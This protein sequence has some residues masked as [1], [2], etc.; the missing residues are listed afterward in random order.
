MVLDE[1]KETDDVFHVNGFTMVVEKKLH[2]QTKDVTV[3]YVYNALGG[4]FQVTSEI[5]VGGGS[6]SPSC[7]C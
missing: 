2:E 7:S 3:D 5:P 4:G 1:P 6:C